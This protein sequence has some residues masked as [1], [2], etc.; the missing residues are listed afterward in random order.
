MKGVPH[1]HFFQESVT[2]MS[3]NSHPKRKEL[4]TE[5]SLSMDS[6]A[7]SGGKSRKLDILA[8][9]CCSDPN[10]PSN[11]SCEMKESP[12][13]IPKV[14]TKPL[15]QEDLD[16]PSEESPSN[17][18]VSLN[19]PP[20][21][22]RT[23][24]SPRDLPPP[25]NGYYRSSPPQPI[26]HPRPRYAARENMPTYQQPH[27]PPPL[28]PQQHYNE[29]KV[30]R[31]EDPPAHYGE[32]RHNYQHYE[33]HQARHHNYENHPPPHY[34]APPPQR[35]QQYED[36]MPRHSAENMISPPNRERNHYPSPPYGYYEVDK[37]SHAPVP[38]N[39][40]YHEGRR[41]PYEYG[42]G[43]YQQTMPSR[44]NS[45]YDDY[46]HRETRSHSSYKHTDSPDYSA[47]HSE[48]ENVPPL[49]GNWQAA[50]PPLPPCPPPLYPNS[51]RD[52]FQAVSQDSTPLSSSS[53]HE[54]YVEGS[55][56]AYDYS[57]GHPE[58][59]DPLEPPHKRVRRGRK[60]HSDPSS[61]GRMDNQ[62]RW[63]QM[64]DRLV[65]FKH[66]HGH[67]FVPSS[68]PPDPI[69]AKWC[70]TQ[71]SM[72]RARQ[73]NGYSTLSDERLRDL[74]EIGFHFAPSH[75][76]QKEQY[77]PGQFHDSNAPVPKIPE[78]RNPAGA[79]DV[80]PGTRYSPAPSS[81][82]SMPSDSKSYEDKTV[83]D[84]TEA[85]EESLD[86]DTD[87][88]S[89]VRKRRGRKPKMDKSERV[90]H[91]T[92]W[93]HMYHQLIEFRRIHGHSHVPSTY[94]PNPALSNWCVTQRSMYRSRNE[95]SYSTLSDD[96]LEM[97]QRVGFVWAI[98]GLTI[99][100]EARFDQLSEYKKEHGTCS[101]SRKD[102]R[103]K[104]LASWVMNQR[105]QLRLLRQGK[106][107]HMTDDRA[108]RLETIGFEE[109]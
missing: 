16:I 21:F 39:H 104:S 5:S 77:I 58:E 78:W 8:S 97:L 92:R 53:R 80:N 59:Y 27:Y 2:E 6:G 17:S 68:Y 52:N 55:S 96:R 44:P 67:C 89:C 13:N 107:S 38:G 35:H 32:E 30:Q 100:W 74:H 86:P 91:Q 23:D 88:Q 22:A 70:T 75:H 69:L 14:V 34:N 51:K 57:D 3:N 94:K 12:P 72:Y 73:E 103:H 71:R 101:V 41:S 46:S 64:L 45:S 47:S 42:P 76:L 66:Q 82:H 40:T 56:Y 99:P 108:R 87:D 20:S 36:Q 62:T 102:P 93:M 85:H 54:N 15:K 31:Y 95:G 28:P 9:V 26:V 43:Y 65:A 33:S 1:S 83:E 10:S 24:S 4:R 98:Q 60:P 79:S 48:G 50:H 63:N 18:E 61:M 49:A 105:T 11:G 109:K 29:N 25:S 7:T 90:D 106:P 81:A 37:R 19:S 84:G